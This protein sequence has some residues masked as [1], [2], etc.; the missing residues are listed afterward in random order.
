[1]FSRRWTDE[2]LQRHRERQAKHH[3]RMADEETAR[4]R[5][6]Y[7][8]LPIASPAKPQA[9]RR[10][11][12]N[13][14]KVTT[15][16]GTFDSTK[17]YRRWQELQLRQSAGEITELRHHVRFA[18]VVEGEHICDYEADF[19]YREGA[20]VIVEDVKPKDAKFRKTLAYRH[21]RLKQKLVQAIHKFQ[22]R[23]V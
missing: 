12:F 22:I 3:E 7:A 10:A 1:M 6:K 23:E 5:A 16:D 19:T 9:A 17:E 11:K 13:N 15:D 8:E 18:A 4:V 14:R 2:D 21:F 20:A